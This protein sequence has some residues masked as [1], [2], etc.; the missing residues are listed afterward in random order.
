MEPNKSRPSLE[1]QF[2]MVDAMAR[3]ELISFCIATDKEF[4]SNW[5]LELIANKLQEIE[6]GKFIERGKKILIVQMP[7]R[8]G[9][10]L[11]T[12]INFAAWFLGKKPT[13]EVITCSYSGDLAQIFGGKTRTKVDSPQFKRIFPGVSLKED[14]KA[15]AHWVTKEEGG[16]TSVGIGGALTGKGCFPAGTLIQTKQ[17]ALPIEKC[18]IGVEVLSYNHKKNVCEWKRVI[19]KRKLFKREFRE[20]TAIDGNRVIASSEH[21]FF[22]FG[23]GYIEAKDLRENQR[24]GLFESKKD[25]LACLYSLQQEIRKGMVRIYQTS[26]SWTKRFLLRNSLFSKSSCNQKQ[27]QMF[28]M[29]ELGETWKQLLFS[30]LY[31]ETYKTRGYLLRTMQNFISSFNQIY[32][33]LF[34]GL[35]KQFS[36][37]FDVGTQS[38][39]QARDG[40]EQVSARI[41]TEKI[42]LK[43]TNQQEMRNLRCFRRINSSSSRLQSKKQSRRK[44][45]IGLQNSSHNSSQIKDYA[46]SSIT[47]FNGEREV[48]DLQ[49]EDN[50]NFFANDFLVHNCDLLIIDDPIKNKEEAQSKLIRDKHWDFFASTAYTRLEPGGVCVIIITRWHLDDLAGRVLANEEFAKKVELISF[51]AIAEHEEQFRKTGE[52]LWPMRYPFDELQS[53]KNALGPYDWS[54]LYQQSPVLSA[55]QEFKQEWIKQVDRS[56]VERLNTRNVLTIDTAMSE[57]DAADYTGFCENYID[58]ENNWNVSA[59]RIRLNAKDLIDYIFTIHAKR[60]FEKIG[61]EKTAYTWGL[62]PFLDSE[63]RKRGVFLPIVEL[64]HQQVNKETRIRG[65]IPR[66]AS[67]SIYH[68]KGECNDLEEEL[69]TFPKSIHDDVSDAAAYQ[70]QIA[71]KAHKFNDPKELAAKYGV[72][73]RWEPGDYGL[74]TY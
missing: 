45:S 13:R 17:G 22:V 5:H 46:I 59:Y 73:E 37:S 23:E 52:A 74:G 3:K 54:S 48:Y 49:I 7:P 66:Y 12:T 63:M 42:S 64:Q 25:S 21:P 10:S 11:T 60:S 65:L 47:A 71:E 61:I 20:I 29:P 55:N 35:Q 33:V 41:S 27:P 53:I 72:E 26:T 56:F 69:L 38:E 39:L 68:I 40:N 58:H 2:L 31:A 67:G 51:P 28:E 43:Q 32:Q 34:N 16:Y 19:A 57:K 8:H 1:E 62:K 44:S 50:H 36:F 15:K 4:V 70:L 18:D 6:S 30:K 9:K 14:E 24:I